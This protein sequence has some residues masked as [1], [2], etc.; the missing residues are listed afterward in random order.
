MKLTAQQLDRAAGAVVG[1]AVGDALGAPYEFGP[2]HPDDFIPQF[3]PGKGGEQPGDWTDDTAMA[4]GILDALAAGH[5]I[6]SDRG[7]QAVIDRWYQWVDE[8]GRGIG[9]QTIQVMGGAK[10]D[11]TEAG[12]LRSSEAAHARTGRSGGNGSLMRIGPLAL[13]YLAPDSER[14][15]QSAAERVTRVTHW[16][17]DNAAAVTIWSLLIRRAI[18]TGELDASGFTDL[19]ADGA[20]RRSRWS[21]VIDEAQAAS[22]PREFSEGNGWVVKAFQAALVAVQGATDFRD[23]IYRAIRGGRDTD[24]VAAIAGALAGARWGLSSIPLSWQRKIHGWP[25]YDANDL[26]R[27]AILAARGGASD[28][29]GWPA[30]DSVLNPHFR[31]TDPVRHPFDDGV[32]LGSQSALSRAPGHGLGGR[33]ARPGR[34]ERGAG[35]RRVHPRLAHR[36]ARREPEP[37][38]DARQRDR[39]HRRAPHR[40]QGGLRPLRRSPI[41][42]LGRCRA[43]R[44]AAPRRVPRRGMELARRT[45]QQRRSPVLRPGTVPAGCGRPDRRAREPS[46]GMTRRPPQHSVALTRTSPSARP[47]G[48]VIQ[49]VQHRL[50]EPDPVAAL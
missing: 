47:R 9:I 48:E 43:L 35:G 11:R 16:E 23:A 20:G 13:G 32:W 4:V 40:G 45:A 46:D 28:S 41:P 18:L 36:H 25:G 21:G 19:V 38:R 15:L 7:I 39:R 27:L 26:A 3:G 44:G 2:S 30:G 24:T 17:P 33:V 14:A 8:D 6:D 1:S 10:E 29:V 22:H 42:H 31:H 34:H 49:R 12:L 50:G 5:D 37:R